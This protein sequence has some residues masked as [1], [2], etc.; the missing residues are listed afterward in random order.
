[1]TGRGHTYR[2]GTMP[3]GT[4]LLTNV[5][6]EGKGARTALLTTE[7]FR[8][9]LE[10]TREHRYDMYDLFL[11]LPRP[12]V[13][14]HLRRVVAGMQPPAPPDQESPAFRPNPDSHQLWIARFPPR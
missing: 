11:K 4:T 10:I 14:R 2:V 3:H 6:I 13:P 9:A 12:L 5:L 8:D 1:M 7:G